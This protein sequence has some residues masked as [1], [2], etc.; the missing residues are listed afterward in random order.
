MHENN[1]YFSG[2]V[3]ADRVLEAVAKILAA[4]SSKTNRFLFSSTVTKAFSI[5]TTT[6]AMSNNN[7]LCVIYYSQKA[8]HITYE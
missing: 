2:S 8:K 7:T 4:R 5:N 6:M 1:D 3:T